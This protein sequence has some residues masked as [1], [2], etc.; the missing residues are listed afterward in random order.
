MIGTIPTYVVIALII[1]SLLGGI[2]ITAIGPGGIFITLFMFSFLSITSAEVA[3]TASFTF[4]F[5]GILATWLYF[6]SG[7]FRIQNGL[8][9]AIIL[10]VTGL[11][12]A[13]L[14][15]LANVITSDRLFGYLLSM[16]VFMMA[17]II[18][19]REY[20]GLKQLDIFM[21]ETSLTKQIILG[22]FGIII[23]FFGGMLGVGGPVLAVPVLLILGVP[24]LS[25]LAI[26]QVQSIFISSFAS[27]GYIRNEAV[28]FDLA[29]LVGL[30][31]LFGVYVGWR[32]AHKIR[33]HILR[34]I[35]A[36]ALILATPIILLW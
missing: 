20:V 17:I 36:I 21:N 1:I 29:I 15:S 26:A 32:I 6:R 24:L 28:L 11:V 31:Q 23:G 4:V 13:Y 27:Y 16:F 5:A 22:V 8:T 3:G 19:Y 12:G 18:L 7:D 2:G 9:A 10:S 30:P 34:P 25:A 35:L 33:P 14:G